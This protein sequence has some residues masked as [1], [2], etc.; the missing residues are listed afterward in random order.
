MAGAVGRVINKSGFSSYVVKDWQPWMTEAVVL[1]ASGMSIPELRVRFGRTDSHIKNVIQTTQA[2][3]IIRKI[4]SNSLKT[5]TS[6]ASERLAA[7]REKAIERMEDLICDD[8]LRKESPFAFWEASRKTLD[9]V[10]RISIPHSAPQPAPS[11][12]IGTVNIQQNTNVQL[13]A[14]N[15]SAMA[16][17][18]AAPTM[19][20]QEVAAN[21]EYLGS[22]PPAGQDAGTVHGHGISGTTPES[23]NGLTLSSRGGDLSAD[24]RGR[25]PF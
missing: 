25:F 23:K 2:T 13:P 24:G 4:Q 9:T 21:V 8:E 18:R 6:Q 19:I 22:P 16:Q 11:T 17:L 5:A 20:P 12:Q 1:H 15:A 14:P 7:L 10:S 3:E